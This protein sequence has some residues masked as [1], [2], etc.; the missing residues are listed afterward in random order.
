MA[1]NSREHV[2]NLTIEAV[3]GGDGGKWEVSKWVESRVGVAQWVYCLP[4][5][6][7]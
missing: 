5:P 4:A 2:H 3:S 1:H 6:R 7:V